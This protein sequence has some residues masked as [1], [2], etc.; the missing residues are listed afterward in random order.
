M[1]GG[2]TA[3]EWVA[4]GPHGAPDNGSIERIF[5]PFEHPAFPK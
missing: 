3:G 4:P 5:A 1:A 2:R